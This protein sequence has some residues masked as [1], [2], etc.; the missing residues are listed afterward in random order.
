MELLDRMNLEIPFTRDGEDFDKVNHTL[1]K[2]KAKDKCKLWDVI[3]NI[4]I[5]LK[6]SKNNMESREEEL[7]G[8]LPEQQIAVFTS[9]M[10][11][12]QRRCKKNPYAEIMRNMKRKKN[13]LQGCGEEADKIEVSQDSH[14]SSNQMQTSEIRECFR[15]FLLVA[16]KDECIGNS[17]NKKKILRE[18]YKLITAARSETFTIRKLIESIEISS[19][20][21]LTSIN[22]EQLKYILIAKFMKILFIYFVAI[23]F[24][25]FHVTFLKEE[26]IFIFNDD[27]SKLRKTFVQRKNY[28][29]AWMS[30][31][32]ADEGVKNKL[33]FF[34][35]GD[36]L[37][38]IVR[39]KYEVGEKDR[40]NQVSSVLSYLYK[41]NFNSKMNSFSVEQWKT[42]KQ[43]K[44][45]QGGS[46]YMISS[47]ICDAYGSILPHK[48]FKLLTKLMEDLPNVLILKE[49]W[50]SQGIRYEV[51]E[52][53]N[54]SKFVKKKHKKIEKKDV[55]NAIKSFLFNTEIKVN[56]K[57]YQLW[58]GIAQGLKLSARLCD[59]YYAD[60]RKKHFSFCD[61]HGYYFTYVDDSLYIC[62][63]LDYAVRYL[64][65]TY[66]G[67]PEYNCWFK[68]EKL[69]YN[70]THESIKVGKVLNKI[71]YLGWRIDAQTLEVEPKFSPS[72]YSTKVNYSSV[73]IQLK[74]FSSLKLSRVTLDKS[75]N[76]REKI[77]DNIVLFASK[78]AA[79]YFV[80]AN[81]LTQSH[82]ELFSKIIPRIN[83]YIWK[84]IV[85]FTS[86]NLDEQKSHKRYVFY[87]MW[88]TFYD[89]FKHKH[90][91]FGAVICQS[92]KMMK[93]WHENRRAR[94][95]PAS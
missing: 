85:K 30:M 18:F 63:N 73:E 6:S 84:K 4:N 57:K 45:M 34:P 7:I 55:I 94:A 69:Q 65:K 29:S 87:V 91:R 51:V 3:S 80:I 20:P 83:Y 71:E 62:N 24:F 88:K 37:R 72:R 21:W 11:D 27:W 70:F 17:R 64:E 61:D 16:I 95:I 76:S 86:W 14:R 93:F 12:L 49:F 28:V 9:I 75:M 44:S 56:N 52:P 58:K 10:D 5:W 74:N 1:L 78:N 25:D 48:L 22:D 42:V 60:M 2:R 50:T 15:L 68:K 90:D 31:G 40:L 67:I 89:I 38:P 53:E 39:H 47:D 77:L 59:I 66:K 41:K 43:D 54:V 23:M 82:L 35:K 13:D 8:K 32:P 36:T 79:R 46:V 92:Q 26:K 19:I 81:S 33:L